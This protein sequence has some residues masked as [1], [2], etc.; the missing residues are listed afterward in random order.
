MGGGSRLCPV[1]GCLDGAIVSR[2]TPTPPGAGM[3]SSMLGAAVR[4]TRPSERAHLTT[5]SDRGCHYRWPKWISICDKAGVT[6]SMSRKGP[7]PGSSRM[8]G[9]S[10]TME[11]EMS[12]GGDWAGITLGEPKEGT[13]AHVG[14]HDKTRIRRSPGSMSP[15]RYRQ[16]LGLA[17]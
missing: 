11:V 6:R 12:H 9:L 16:G 3:A 7:S 13:D 5:H 14:R 4:L 15:L 17:A 10:G 8:G 2:T 1:S